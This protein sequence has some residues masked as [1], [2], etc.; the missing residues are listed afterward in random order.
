MTR[1]DPCRAVYPVGYCYPLPST[2][3]TPRS[4]EVRLRRFTDAMSDRKPLLRLG[5][6]GGSMEVVTRSQE[7]RWPY[8]NLSSPAPELDVP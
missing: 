4:F 5:A 2:V 3:F 1:R 7:Q 6:E 8:V